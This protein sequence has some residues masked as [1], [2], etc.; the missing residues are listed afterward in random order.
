[1]IDDED[2]SSKPSDEDKKNE[3]NTNNQNELIDSLPSEEKPFQ[4]HSTL[5]G[6]LIEKI[7]DHQK[8][9]KNVARD[10]GEAADQE[11]KGIESPQSGVK[12]NETF[13]SDENIL[14]KLGDLE[15][16]QIEDIVTFADGIATK[17]SM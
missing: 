3:Q 6:N 4:R 7:D 10:I 14:D 13:N 11:Q 17:F 16:D 15:I 5:L 2:T 9:L 1:M 12:S 8:L